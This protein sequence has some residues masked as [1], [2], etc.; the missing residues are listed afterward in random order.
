MFGIDLNPRIQPGTFSSRA[1]PDREESPLYTWWCIGSGKL[2]PKLPETSRSL[3]Y[4]R[5]SWPVYLHQKFNGTPKLRLRESTVGD[6]WRPFWWIGRIMFF[7][8]FCGVASTYPTVNIGP[9]LSYPK[10]P[11][12]LKDHKKGLF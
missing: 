10:Y 7:S 6:F 9:F 5:Q 4:N 3:E 8:Q 11:D 2:S 12:P 1:F